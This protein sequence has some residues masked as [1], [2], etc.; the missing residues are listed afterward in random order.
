MSI[1]S[2]SVNGFGKSTL[3]ENLVLQNISFKYFYCKIMLS[4]VLEALLLLLEALYLPRSNTVRPQQIMHSASVATI[5][6]TYI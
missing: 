2:Y 3:I 1:A 5:R 6:T 4:L